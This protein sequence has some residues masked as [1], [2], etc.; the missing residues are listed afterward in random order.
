MAWLIWYE[1]K[2]IFLRKVNVAAM[3]AGIALMAVIIYIRVFQNYVWN[4]KTQDW[5]KG[6]ESFQV[7][8]EHDA[9]LTDFLTEEFLSREIKRLQS[10]GVDLG[11]DQAYVDY[12][13]QNVS[14]WSLVIEN[15]TDIHEYVQ[16]GILNEIGREGGARFYETR[17]ERVESYL[18]KDFSYGNFTQPEKDFWMEKLDEAST[19]FAWG[20]TENMTVF[21]IVTESLLYCVFA[22]ILCAAPIFSSEFESG[23]AALLL[24]TKRG[25]RKLTFAKIIAAAGFAVLYQCALF[26]TAAGVIGLLIG[27]DGAEL[28]VQLAETKIPYPWSL[29]EA[30]GINFLLILLVSIAM[31]LF[32]LFWSARLKNSIAVLAVSLV[33]MIAPVMFPMSKTSGLWNHINYLFP[34]RAMLLR[35]VLS[36]YNSYAFGSLVISYVGMIVAVYAAVCILCS[37]LTVISANR[38]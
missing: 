12:L 19:P 26:G 18:N 37:C 22:L 20:S 4:P 29:G 28:P 5:T 13:R 35:D 11:S 38:G 21:W 33:V 14:L 23:A 2:K 30:I 3:L 27:Y 10:Y 7:A 6:I 32:T 8:K 25:R 17:R 15:Y 1:W 34:V 36:I 31:T 24:T 16:W 9:A